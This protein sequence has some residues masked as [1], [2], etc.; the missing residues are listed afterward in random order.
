MMIAFVWRFRGRGGDDA[1]L[2]ALATLYI[3]IVAMGGDYQRKKGITR[4]RVRVARVVWSRALP[5]DFA[6]VPDDDVL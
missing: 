3:G 1:L 2:A 4:T 6:A 5:L